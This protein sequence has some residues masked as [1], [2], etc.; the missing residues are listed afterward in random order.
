VPRS[1]APSKLAALEI[2]NE[3]LRAEVVRLKRLL[4]DANGGKAVAKT[5]SERMKAMRERRKQSV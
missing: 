3:A 2:E 1:V 4:S 5:A